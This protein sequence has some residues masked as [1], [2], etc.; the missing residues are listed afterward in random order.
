MKARFALLSLL[1]L[2]VLAAPARAAEVANHPFLPQRTI[3]GGMLPPPEGP[4]VYEGACGAAVSLSGDIFIS[5][6]YHHRVEIWRAGGA[7]AEIDAGEF[8]NGPCG[9]AVDS[10]NNVYVN[11]WHGKVVRYTPPYTSG[12]VIYDGHA[13]GVAIDPVSDDLY[14]DERTSVAR[15]ASPVEPEDVAARFGQGSLGDGFG[16]AFS[17]FAATEGRVYAADG[18]SGTVKAYDSSSPDDP[19]AEIDGAGTPSGGFVSLVDSA[20]ATDQSNGHLFVADNL[21]AGFEHPAAAVDEFNADGLYRGRLPHALIHAEPT[22]IAVNESPSA[23]R[24]EVYV[25]SGNGSSVV[26]P[27]SHETPADEISVLYGFGP[28]GAGQVLSVATSGSGSGTV[29]SSPAGIACPGACEAEFNS[30]ATVTLTA[31]SDSGS[32][33]SGWSGACTGS[34]SCQVALNSS[35]SVTA[36]FSSAPALLGA[37]RTMATAAAAPSAEAPASEAPS[38]R[39]GAA[40]VHGDV[41]T[42]P[43]TAPGAGSLVAGGRG[44]RRASARPSAAGIVSLHLRLNWR[45]R[46][47]LARRRSGRLA[48]HVLVS[49]APSR[50]GSELVRG[51]NVVFQQIGR[52]SR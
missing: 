18:A 22:G 12:E 10:A 35:A 15:Y 21:Q 36:E 52:K 45:G 31:T 1:V 14:V 43:V 8:D 28:A 24:G 29:T 27:P 51:R 19:V 46:A 34:G 50:A 32:V 6:Y 2:V 49:F 23:R 41:V 11:F 40:S 26:F 13:T 9:L 42:L 16:V 25:T 5:D 33:F 7:H 48:V 30:G 4:R 39:L 37:S 44:L 47:A 38:F 3:S 17:D 20:L